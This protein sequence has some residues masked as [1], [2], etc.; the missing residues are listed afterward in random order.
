MIRIIWELDTT[1]LIMSLC[2]GEYRCVNTMPSWKNISNDLKGAT[3]AAHPPVKGHKVISKPSEVRHPTERKIIP[4]KET[5]QT[6]ASLPSSGRPSRFSPESDHA[7][8][9]VGQVR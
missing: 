4:K 1:E 9:V 3:V 5:S 8:H 2:S 7:C 6:A